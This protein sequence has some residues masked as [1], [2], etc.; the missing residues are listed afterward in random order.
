MNKWGLILIFFTILL[1]LNIF[2][3]LNISACK[4]IIAVDN[5]TEGDFNL[6][7]KVRDPSRPGLQVLTIVPKG[8]EYSYHHPWT[9]KSMNFKVENKFIGVVSHGDSIPQI[10]KPGMALTEKGLGFGD[11]DSG[12]MWINPTKYGWD[13]FDWIRYA[14]QTA[15]YE[16]EAVSLLTKDVVK[17]LHA[18]KV[19]ENLFIIGPETG[20]VV[21]AD[22]FHFDIKN[23][24]DV[25][26]MSNYPKELWK[27]S[28]I[29]KIYSPRFDTTFEGLVRKG[30][31]VRLG[32]GCI[33]GIKIL[34]INSNSIKV[35][36]LPFDLTRD[37][38]AGP[39]IESTKE[40]E[41]KLGES[42]KIGHFL[43]K[44]LDI[45]NNKAEIY[46]C[47][48]YKEWEELMMDKI[49]QK[50]GHITVSDI[51]SWSRLHS[52]DLDGLRSICGLKESYSREG[53]VIYKIPSED[54]ETLSEGW[55]SPNHPCSSIYVPFHI[56]NTD[57]YKPYKNGEAAQIS[58]NLLD[59]YDHGFLHNYFQKTEEVFFYELEY[60]MNFTN[61]AIDISEYLTEIDMSMQRQ[62][63]WTQEMWYK[64]DTFSNN[65]DTINE[66]SNIWNTSYL[67]SLSNMKN[68]ILNLEEIHY[69]EFFI[70]KIIDI[71]LD[72]CRTRINSCEQ[73]GID[74]TE[75][76]D[77]FQNGE[78][79]LTSGDYENGCEILE[80]VYID[81]NKLLNGEELQSLSKKNP[82][83]YIT[84]NILS[85]G[86]ISGLLVFI[87]LVY[88]SNKRELKNYKNH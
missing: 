6:L 44:L 49:M 82:R 88:Y 35:K 23:V 40:Y 55:F 24:E 78:E 21:E 30:Q 63:F 51:I 14:C 9:G 2:S 58:L 15:D 66:I 3:I 71:I 38:I 32:L 69:S 42:E 77:N 67:I 52:W 41:I 62:A 68:S 20:Y 28:L 8:Y 54:Y 73:L 74:I 13:D 37:N 46:M 87:C 48:E 65:E 53:A 29:Y 25:V 57:F 86:F 70:E 19:A 12:V 60:L 10:V 16:E 75:I 79:I 26:V 1:V 27:K 83:R 4:N 7:L 85:I 22:A 47:Y 81:C 45:T 11:A 59:I 84:S 17:K 39:K 50:Y 31:R 33:F 56:C 76:K 72:I 43:I 64:A 5:S 80:Q 61:Q 36:L 34:E 18:T